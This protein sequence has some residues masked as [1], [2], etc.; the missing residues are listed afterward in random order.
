MTPF[1]RRLQLDW[2]G[3]CATF[4]VRLKAGH[5]RR[6]KDKTALGVSVIVAETFLRGQTPKACA[7]AREDAV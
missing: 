6:D 2:G 3:I 4:C 7:P 5:G 1:L